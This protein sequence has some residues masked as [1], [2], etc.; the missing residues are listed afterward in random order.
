M[1]RE[2]KSILS[3]GAHY[4]PCHSDEKGF[5]KSILLID[6][7]RRLTFL[8]GH[9]FQYFLFNLDVIYHNN[10]W[11]VDEKGFKNLIL[12]IEEDRR[13]TYY[14]SPLQW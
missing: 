3:L 12:Q 6:N 5:K 11:K 2:T 13:L 14:Q 7:D 8:L 9:D 1:I 4:W 10:T